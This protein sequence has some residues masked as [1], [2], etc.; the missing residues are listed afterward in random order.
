MADNGGS[1]TLDFRMRSLKIGQPAALA[2][3]FVQSAVINKNVD[4]PAKECGEIGEGGLNWLLRLD[5]ASGT[6]R[7]GGAPISDDPF[8]TGYCFL[9]RDARGVP[10]PVSSACVGYQEARGF[11]SGVMARVDIPIYLNGDPKNVLTLP[12]RGVSFSAQ[13]SADSNCI[14]LFNGGALNG[15]CQSEED[16]CS[17]WPAGGAVSGYI[18]LEAADEVNVADLNE[19]LCV[20]LTSSVK[21]PATNKCKRDASGAIALKGDACSDPSANCQDS[22]LFKA[23]FAASAV[24]IHA[25]AGVPDCQ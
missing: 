18:P 8:G 24:H 11:T 12:L 2:S 5:I 4:L 23:R 19:S 9:T 7:T 20:L 13:V 25:G 17:K 15:Q 10:A 6:L 16:A 22:Y 1:S 21:D 14:G 3:A